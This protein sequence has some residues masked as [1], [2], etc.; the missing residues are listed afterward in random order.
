MRRI[1]IYVRTDE[2][3]LFLAY[4]KPSKYLAE[5]H[6]TRWT[7]MVVDLEKLIKGNVINFR[8]HYVEDG[9]IIMNFYSGDENIVSKMASVVDVIKLSP[10]FSTVK[11]KCM[12]DE[13]YHN[14]INGNQCVSIGSAIY[15]NTKLRLQ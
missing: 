3:D 6:P 14:D 8:H 10:D 1:S 15:E 5:S 12:S 13:E 7:E 9:M 2:T 11:I 4:E